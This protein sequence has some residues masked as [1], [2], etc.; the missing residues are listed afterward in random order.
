MLDLYG[1]HQLDSGQV[2]AIVSLVAASVPNLSADHV[3]VVDQ[4]GHLMTDESASELGLSN[5]QFKYARKIEESYIKRIED[6][7]S[8]IVGHS[9][10]KAEVTV[11][12]DFTRTEQ[13]REIYNPDL[14]A[15]RS[16]QVEEE[17]RSGDGFVGGIPGA[18]SNQPATTARL[19]AGQS[20]NATLTEQGQSSASNTQ[21]RATRNYELI[22]PSATHVCRWA[23][24][25]ECRSLFYL[26]I[27]R[28]SMERVSRHEL[29]I[30][31][32]NWFRSLLWLKNLSDT[33]Q[34]EVIVSVL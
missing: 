4:K 31:R 8:P 30:V 15:L 3:S 9:G 33:M 11:E 1:G 13:T 20:D 7:L 16:E 6:I 27:N 17:S 23:P 26:T 32:K 2:A 10:V 29:N 34:F 5:S 18:L 28:C 22:K 12:F 24:S 14:P 19:D 25:E 21:M